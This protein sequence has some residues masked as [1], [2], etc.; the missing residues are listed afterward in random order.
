M[1]LEGEVEVSE[2]FFA[3]AKQT[4]D[5]H[6]RSKAYLA[7]DANLRLT[8]SLNNC[9]TLVAGGGAGFK[10]GRHLVMENKTPLCNLWLSALHGSG[11][12]VDTFGDANGV[13]NEL[14]EA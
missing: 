6:E 12:Q 13:I 10:H 14:F 2:G 8:H 7:Q 4:R 1:R 3:Q 9:P 5:N 11:V